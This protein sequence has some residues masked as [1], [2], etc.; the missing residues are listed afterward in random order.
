MNISWQRMI[1]SLLL[2]GFLWA[3]ECEEE[4]FVEPDVSPASVS[5]EANVFFEDS[6]EAGAFSGSLSGSIDTGAFASEVEFLEGTHY[7][8]TGLPETLE[9]RLVAAG[10]QRINLS[11]G[12]MAGNHA[13]ADSGD[14]TLTLIDE[15]FFEEKEAPR[16]RLYLSPEFWRMVSGDPRSSSRDESRNRRDSGIRSRS[17]D[18]RFFRC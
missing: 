2:P 1:L 7:K 13:I 17:R 5:W 9:V 18:P 4:P 3:C 10:S 8:V 15:A 11:L 14:F 12:S 16:K 6:N